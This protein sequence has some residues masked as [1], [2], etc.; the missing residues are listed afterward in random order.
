MLLRSP[1]RTADHSIARPGWRLTCPRNVVLPGASARGMLVR[2]P[3]RPSLAP[4]ASTLVSR[5][6]FLSSAAL[7]PFAASAA[8][9]STG[10]GGAGSRPVVVASSNGLKAAE[11]A[12]E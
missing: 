8:G 7:A 4:G 10:G 9:P 6:T 1:V 11:L 2:E 12:V 3:H 5:R